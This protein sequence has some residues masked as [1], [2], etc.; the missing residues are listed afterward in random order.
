MV[1]RTIADSTDF[2]AGQGSVPIRYSVS[3]PARVITRVIGPELDAVIDSQLVAAPT[4]QRV[5]EDG[6]FTIAGAA[7][8]IVSKLTS[9]MK[10][11]VVT[12]SCYRARAALY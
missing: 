11:G 2:V 9:K 1:H 4:L 7:P 8:E 6:R 3:R 5:S 12:N 10:V